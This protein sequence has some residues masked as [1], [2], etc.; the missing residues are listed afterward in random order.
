MKSRDNLIR[1]FLLSIPLVMLYYW[2]AAAD[3]RF[4]WVHRPSHL[5]I[6]NVRGG[7][8]PMD[9]YPLLDWLIVSVILFVALFLFGFAT[10]RIHALR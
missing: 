5:R 7:C 6:Y 2:R 9:H 4:E 3:W 1:S 10:K 8:L